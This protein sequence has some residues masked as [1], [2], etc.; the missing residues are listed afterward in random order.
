MMK[1]VKTHESNKKL[2]SITRLA[3]DY[4]RQLNYE[5]NKN[6]CGIAVEAAKQEKR[7]AKQAA[8]KN[9]RSRWQE[10]P[11]HGQFR[12]RISNNDVDEE[13]TLSWLKSSN[14]KAETEGFIIAAQ[15]QSLK[16]KNYIANIMKIGSDSNCRYCKQQKETIDHLISGCSILATKEYLIRHDKVGKYIHWKLCKHYNIPTTTNWYEHETPPVMTNENAT[17]LWDFSI[18]TDKTIKANRPDIIIKD[19]KEKTCLMLDVSI[20]SDKNTSLKIYEKISKYKDLEIELEKTW[21]LKTKTI[22]IVIGALGVINIST[23]KYL[24]QLPTPINVNELQKITLLGTA[25]ILR[26]AL[27]LSVA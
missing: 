22:P 16:T 3:N 13:K 23:E 15:D 10:K 18:Q 9:L 19:K 11:L 1:C 8:L 12:K 6:E 4:H 27:S 24:K 7:T 26:K 25:T 2:Y 14:L 21:K 17:I 20:P 5:E